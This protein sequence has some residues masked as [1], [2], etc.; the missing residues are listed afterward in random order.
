MKKIFFYTLR[1][2]IANRDSV[3][4]QTF[5]VIDF[6]KPLTLKN[7]TDISCGKCENRIAAIEDEAKSQI[8]EHTKSSFQSY[9]LLLLTI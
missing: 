9:D 3:F 6:E 2:S 1:S 4:V 8:F 5:E 7:I